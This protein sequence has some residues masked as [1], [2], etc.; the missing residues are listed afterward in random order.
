MWYC[1]EAHRK[2]LL[3]K[4]DMRQTGQIEN[5]KFV[6]YV[7]S[8]TLICDVAY[9]IDCFAKQY[10]HVGTMIRMKLFED[11]ALQTHYSQDLRKH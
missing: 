5:I 8:S 7:S 3:V 2:Q 6:N 1:I 11:V 4:H 9:S 10:Q